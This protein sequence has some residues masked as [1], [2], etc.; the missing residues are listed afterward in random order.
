MEVT[1]CPSVSVPLVRADK[2]GTEGDRNFEFGENIPLVPL[3]DNPIL[4]QMS[5][6][7]RSRG[8]AELW[9][10]RCRTFM[11]LDLWPLNSPELSPID[12]QI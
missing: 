7:S 1:V 8:P 12:C 11:T 4:G 9:N 3:N 5:Q 10:R 2:S 6:K